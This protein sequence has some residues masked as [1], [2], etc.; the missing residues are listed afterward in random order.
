M[1]HTLAHRDRGARSS[2]R[3][4]DSYKGR[5]LGRT[6][7]WVRGSQFFFLKGQVN[8]LGFV[9]HEVLVPATGLAIKGKQP[10]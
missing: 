3:Q 5:K 9:N 2:G 8:I 1:P 7:I 6:D 10:C 4:R